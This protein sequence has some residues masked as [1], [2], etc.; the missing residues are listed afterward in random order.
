MPSKI[1]PSFLHTVAATVWNLEDYWMVVLSSKALRLVRIHGEMSLKIP[2]QEVV[3]REH[4]ALFAVNG[5]S[6]LQH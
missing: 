2:K 6:L 1:F 4:I 3:V 5:V